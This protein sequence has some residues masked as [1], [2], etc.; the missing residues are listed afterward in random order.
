MRILLV[1]LMSFMIGAPAAAFS[2]ADRAAI[3]STIERQLQ[4]F[5]ADDAATAYSFASPGIKAL[6]PTKDIF[7]DMVR[8]GY[9]PVY[10]PRQ[11]AFGA[12]EEKAGHLEQSVDIIDA[13]GEAWTALYTLEMQ[14][15][16][17]WKITGCMLLKKPG[18]V[19]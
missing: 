18:K 14:P 3:Q 17:S 12:L 9:Q 2:D 7:M 10:R 5:L 1:L 11:H 13:N 4:A 15:D 19:A 8:Q 6:F 16:G